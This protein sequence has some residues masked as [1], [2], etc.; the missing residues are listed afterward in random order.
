MTRR[1][2]LSRLVVALAVLVLT[3]A[4]C[5]GAPDSTITYG[6]STWLG[7]YP[8]MVAVKKNIFT[9]AGLDVTFKNFD[10]SSAR[11][12]AVASGDVDFASTGAVSAISLMAAGDESFV[13]IGTQDKYLR[14]E[15]LVAQRDITSVADLRGKK[16]AV[17]FS[18]SSHVILLDLLEQA[19]LDPATDVK[20]VNM[21]ESDMIQPFRSG[22]IDAAVVWQPSFAE[23]Q[24]LPGAHV[25]ADDTDT[26]FFRKYGFAPG[27][28]VLVLR[29]EFAE[30]SPEQAHQ[31]VDAYFDAVDEL[32]R[33]PQGATSVL[34]DY[35]KL[36]PGEQRAYLADVRWIEA[37]EQQE[38]MA[39]DGKFL[40]ALTD[41][42]SLM[43]RYKLV[44]SVPNV[45]D[46][47]STD[48]YGKH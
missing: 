5:T 20:L 26:T 30:E 2:R 11:M 44:D 23:L 27:P 6:G 19:G 8:A 33:N 40:H 24:K 25:V 36:P 48:V 22:Q 1:T 42:A 17:T 9:D 45:S 15:G 28:D 38:Y 12:T 29:K 39:P 3:L 18:S 43:H 35:T 10:T 13:V 4:G 14:Q 37:A 7:H 21:S 34:T 31:V 46:W 41:L 16:I 32:Q 47:V